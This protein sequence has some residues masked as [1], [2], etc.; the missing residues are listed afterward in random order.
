VLSYAR[1]EQG[2]HAGRKETLALNDLLAR[3]LQPLERRAESA[4]LRLRV[5]APVEEGERTIT[6]D[7]E[8]VERI[9]FNLVDNAVKY[10]APSAGAAPPKASSDESPASTSLGM[11]LGDAEATEAPRELVLRVDADAEGVRL[12]VVDHGP[13]VPKAQQARL[14]QPFERGSDDHTQQQRGL[15]L[16]LALSRELARILGGD[17]LHQPTPGGGATFTLVLGGT[18]A[19]FAPS[20]RT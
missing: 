8:S 10:G 1:I 20:D 5:E 13:G 4:G 7:P 9:L 17:L 18:S 11:S 6:T 19:E 12:S 15:G 14:F 16:G 2:R 3:V